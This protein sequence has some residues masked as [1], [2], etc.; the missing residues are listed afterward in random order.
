[1][2]LNYNNLIIAGI[3][4]KAAPERISGLLCNKNK[5]TATDNYIL[6]EVS[7]NKDKMAEVEKT[8]PLMKTELKPENKSII[9]PASTA[10]NHAKKLSAIKTKYLPSLYYAYIGNYKNKTKFAPASAILVSTN[11]SSVNKEKFNII[12]GEFP[13]YGKIIPENNLKAVVKLDMGKLKQICDIFK[14]IK[15]DRAILELR[16][17][18]EVIVIRGENNQKQKV[19]AL[20]MPIVSN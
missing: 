10:I 5:S 20:L 3:I 12:D 6:I 19:L 2:F 1:M 15:V 16:E 18:N 7:N 17:E 9:I 8:Y 11:L 13:E 14:K 4:S